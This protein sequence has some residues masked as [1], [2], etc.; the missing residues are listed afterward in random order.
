LAIQDQTFSID[1]YTLALEGF[2]VHWLKT[3]GPITWDFM[4]RSM[5]FWH[6]DRA[7]M[8]HGIG[9]DEVSLAAM[10]ATRDLMNSI[11]QDYTDLFAEPR[12]LSPARRHDH[13][14]HLLPGMAPIAIRQYRYPQLLKDEIECQCQEMLAHGIIRETTSPFSSP[15]LLVKKHDGTWR[16]CMDFQALND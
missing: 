14:I 1:C 4:A 3:L 12:G 9:G 13:H 2:D 7:V 15:V 11:L 8:W 5:A 16:F 6:H 10:T